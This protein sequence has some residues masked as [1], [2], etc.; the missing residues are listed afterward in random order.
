[1]G[2]T[3]SSPPFSIALK[4]RG[5]TVV[6]RF[7]RASDLADFWEKC[8][9][10]DIEYWHKKYHGSPESEPEISQKKT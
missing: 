2:Y 4:I 1:M 10:G 8:R 3:K 7:N 5:T 9:P 6:K